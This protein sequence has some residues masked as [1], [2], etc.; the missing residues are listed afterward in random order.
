M[1]QPFVDALAH[2]VYDDGARYIW[3]FL[4]EW[5]YVLVL[6]PGVERRK[7]TTV[8]FAESEDIHTKQFEREF[9]TE[10]EAEAACGPGSNWRSRGAVTRVKPIRT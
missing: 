5:Q 8:W 9:D 7:I 3:A 6:G 1:R 10:E 2:H 4:V